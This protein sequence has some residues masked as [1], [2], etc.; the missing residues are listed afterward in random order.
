M[1]DHSELH[2]II[3]DRRIDGRQAPHPSHRTVVRPSSGL[4][5]SGSS[6]NYLPW[7]SDKQR[8]SARDAPMSPVTVAITRPGAAARQAARLCFRS[9]SEYPSFLRRWCDAGPRLSAG[10]R[11]IATPNDSQSS[12]TTT[13]GPAARD[14]A[15]H[16]CARAQGARGRL[17]QKRVRSAADSAPTRPPPSSTSVFTIARP[18]PAPPLARSRDFSTR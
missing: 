2:E 10:D 9:P 7:S 6:T 1:L 3:R 5:P 14:E 13:S 17:N 15:A 18:M 11:E 8:P 16:G 4:C 12:A